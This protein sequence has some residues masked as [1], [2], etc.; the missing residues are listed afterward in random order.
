MFSSLRLFHIL[1]CPQ[2]DHCSRIRCVFSH[3]SNLPSEQSLD[4]PYEKPA[5]LD[6]KASDSPPARAPDAAVIPA[7]R[8]I[9][10]AGIRRSA[11]PS[12]TSSQNGEPPR[13]LQKLGPTQRPLA[14]PTAS[15][16]TTGVPLLKVNAAQSQVAVPVR[17]AM[18]KTIFDHYSVLYEL[19]LPAYPTLASEHAL[20]QEEDVY[21]VSTKFTY[22]NAVITT[23]ASLKRRPVPDGISHPSVGTERD[24]AEREEARKSLQALRLSRSPLQ[25]LVLSVEDMQKWGYIVAAPEA[26]GGTEPAIEGKIAKCERCVQY[27]QVKRREEAGECVHHWGR[28]YTKMIE[29]QRSRIYSCCSSPAG[30][31]GGCVTGTHVFYESDAETLHARHAFTPT[32]SPTDSDTALDVVALDCEMVYTTGGFRCARVSVVDGAGKEIFDELVRMDDGVEVI[33]YNTRFSGIT[34]EA[35]AKA[36]LPLAA[37]RA[38]LD[39]FINSETIIIGH[40]LENDV[41]TLRMIHHRCVDTAILFP[42]RAGAPYRRSLRDLVRE[43]LGKIIQTGGGTT[44]HSSVEDSVAT[45]DLVR[46]FIL[47]QSKISRTPATPAPSALKSHTT[48]TVT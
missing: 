16:T 43:H 35:H 37:I 42:H 39:S 25:S 24:I 9:A 11:A 18:L 32:R 47:N 7:K 28:P 45:L 48:A 5:E 6:R 3:E 12:S 20:R 33:D 10:S 29:G 36:V 27:F 44:G 23:V 15:H 22:R 2:R 13:K 17:Q 46:W 38:S 34:E 30:D 4:I 19:I 8:P 41:K 31:G 40:G 14:V 1:P 21:K 26:P